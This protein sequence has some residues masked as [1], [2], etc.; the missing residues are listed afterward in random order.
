MLQ[1]AGFQKGDR[2]SNTVILYD[3]NNALN[4]FHN[5]FKL[6]SL[7]YCII[8]TLQERGNVESFMAYKGLQTILLTIVDLFAES[9]FKLN[10]IKLSCKQTD[11]QVQR[12]N[13]LFK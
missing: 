13:I 11:D 5:F 3:K 2:C 8:L 9:A 12:H 1:F 7:F 4:S 6:F 10:N